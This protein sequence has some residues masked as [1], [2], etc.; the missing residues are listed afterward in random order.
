MWRAYYEDGSFI[1]EDGR[2]GGAYAAIDRSKLRK[3]VLYTDAGTKLAGFWAQPSQR[4]VF[5]RRKKLK[6][7]VESEVVL[8]AF[9]ND[10]RSKVEVHML[11]ER[12]VF[13]HLELPFYA[14][15]KEHYAPELLP[16]E[17]LCPRL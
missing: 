2:P 12:P 6:D 3:F 5:R 1:E 9:E 13:M 14:E 7:G 15:D 17:V 11:T 8:V 16:E 4:L 10:D